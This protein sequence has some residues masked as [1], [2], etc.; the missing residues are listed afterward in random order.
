MIIQLDESKWG[1]KRKYNNGRMVHEGF[2]V[3]GAIDTV[4]KKVAI[5]K[6]ADRKETTL[7]A[8]IEEYIL[9]HTII[10]TDISQSQQQ[11]DSLHTHLGQPQIKLC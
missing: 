2:W 3:F 8:L 1:G 6:V 4:T 7:M 9:P 5:F 10:H 11:G